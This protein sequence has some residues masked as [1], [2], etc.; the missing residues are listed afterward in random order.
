MSEQLIKNGQLAADDW[1]PV[2]LAADIE[3]ENLAEAIA[4][5]QIPAGRVLL[6][7]AVWLSRRDALLDRA[8]AGE[9]AVSLAPTFRVEDIAADLSR[10]AMVAVEFPKF[11]DGRGYSTARLLRERYGYRGELRA[12]GDIGRDQLFEL[13]RVGCDAFLLPPGRDAAAALAALNDF[14]EVYQGAVDQPLPLFRRR[15]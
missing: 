15:A 8:A 6:P 3:P 4:A 1:Q 12:V 14:P 5:L 10:F 13:K 2:A 7:A 9:I 11:S